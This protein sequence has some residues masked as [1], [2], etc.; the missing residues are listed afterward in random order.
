MFNFL[1]RKNEGDDWN[2]LFRRQLF[3]WEEEDLSSLYEYLQ[4]VPSLRSHV[5]DQST[6]LTN[7]SGAFSVA[8][9][10]N[11]MASRKGCNLRFVMNIWKNIA[12]PKV[13]FMT[14]SAWRG[15]MKSTAFIQRFGV[16]KP[17]ASILC[18]FCKT[19]VET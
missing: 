13:Q 7:P 11:W 14:W 9:V 3:A 5:E 15:R 10:W 17:N 18:V 16:L 1:Q 2:L 12:P 19:E 8:S 4:V 6:W